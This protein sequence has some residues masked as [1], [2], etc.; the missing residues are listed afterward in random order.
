MVG[1]SVNSML[2][3]YFVVLHFSRLNLTFPCRLYLLIEEGK[4]KKKK[5]GWLSIIGGLSLK[6]AICHDF[7]MRKMCH[8]TPFEL[9]IS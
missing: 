7:R 9:C 1:S 6:R 8:S 3:T 5:K 2:I 4:E